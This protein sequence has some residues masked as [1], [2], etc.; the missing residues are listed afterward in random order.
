MQQS[1]KLPTIKS[2]IGLILILVVFF[3]SSW[4]VLAQVRPRGYLF[5]IGGGVRP[6]SMMK[7][8]VELATKSGSGRIVVLPMASA[9]PDETGRH[10]VEEF[11]QL[12]AKEAVYY[13]FNRREAE[14]YPNARLLAESG[15]IFFSGG[16]QSRITEA[17]LDTPIHNMIKELYQKGAVIGGTSAGAAVMSE[18]MITGDEA[19]KPEEGHEFETIESGNIIVSRGLGLINSAVIDQHFATRKRHNRLISIIAGHPELLGIGIDE[20]TAIIV[21]PD[22]TFE[23]IGSKNVIVYDAKKSKIEV[24]RDKAI[25]IRGLT[26]H[27]LLEGE[28]FDL[29]K[30]RPL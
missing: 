24:R 18:L 28:R 27:V 23:V 25:S 11:L 26:M 17:I 13:N 1:K 2:L 9:T 22:E 5:I 14:K 30:R 19:R 12:G 7:R 15:G 20:S 16:V 21:Y 3:S 4:P 10:L 29:K 8:F 6:E